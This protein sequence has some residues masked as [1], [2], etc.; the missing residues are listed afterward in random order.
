MRCD[1]TLQKTNGLKLEKWA[2]V[3]GHCDNLVSLASQLWREV[4]CVVVFGLPHYESLRNDEGS[5]N[6]QTEQEYSVQIPLWRSSTTVTLQVHADMGQPL[7]VSCPG[8]GYDLGQWPSHSSARAL[9]GAQSLTTENRLLTAL[10]AGGTQQSPPHC[11]KMAATTGVQR[12]PIC[13]V[14][15]NIHT[16]TPYPN[17]AAWIS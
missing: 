7:A 16:H 10:T 9:P 4:E 13:L 14:I 8:K 5:T 3:E 17:L 2:C 6:G 15:D 1:T 11:C 12:D